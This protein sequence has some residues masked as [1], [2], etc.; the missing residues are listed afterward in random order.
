MPTILCNCR[1]DEIDL[2]RCAVR[3]QA[4]RGS[5]E[6]G[7]SGLPALFAFRIVSTCNW[8]ISYTSNTSKPLEMAMPSEDEVECI[9]G[10]SS[11]NGPREASSWH[12]DGGITDDRQPASN[13]AGP[14]KILIP[15][16]LYIAG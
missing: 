10:R 3:E 5:K 13:S 15:F 7:F 9:F 2:G 8:S 16:I 4:E 11:R 12:D 14:Y 1:V 6:M